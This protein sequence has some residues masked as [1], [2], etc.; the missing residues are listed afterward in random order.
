MIF[1]Y[2]QWL[3]Y[4]FYI[5]RAHKCSQWVVDEES[6]VGGVVPFCP[7]NDPQTGPTLK[8]HLSNLAAN[9]QI[10][11]FLPG[12]FLTT[13]FKGEEKIFSELTSK[14]FLLYDFVHNALCRKLSGTI[15]CQCSDVGNVEEIPNYFQYVSSF[16]DSLPHFLSNSETNFMLR[17]N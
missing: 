9:Y 2:H 7:A 12:R 13:N 8:P 4:Y 11:H 17:R 10:Y 5:T 1:F 3:V 16:Q 15:I 14:R 6:R